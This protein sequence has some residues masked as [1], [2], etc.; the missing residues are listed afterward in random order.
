MQ[1]GP[2]DGDVWLKVREICVCAEKEREKKH[3]C[4][5][6]TNFWFRVSNQVGWW[7]N[8]GDKQ[9]RP[10]CAAF[11]LLW[12]VSAVLKCPWKVPQNTDCSLRCCRTTNPPTLQETLWINVMHHITS[13]KDGN[14]LFTQVYEDLSD[15]EL[16]ILLSYGEDI[17]A[18]MDS[19]SQQYSLEYIRASVSWYMCR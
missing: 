4:F 18:S 10:A 3:S 12:W 13:I 7:F 14:S 9:T 19:T 15:C 6:G 17:A 8:N 2:T 5:T 11:C 16:G 1:L